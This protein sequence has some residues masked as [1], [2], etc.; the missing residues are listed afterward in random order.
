MKIE[1]YEM[2]LLFMVLG[3]TEV[4][5]DLGVKVADPDLFPRIRKFF[6]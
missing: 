2:F 3:T 5:R 6:T 4:E 1:K